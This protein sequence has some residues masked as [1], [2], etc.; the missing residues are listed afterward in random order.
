MCLSLLLAS[1]GSAQG[2]EDKLTGIVRFEAAVR[3]M[4]DLDRGFT[5]FYRTGRHA[6]RGYD[7]PVAIQ[8]G[9]YGLGS[10]I[11]SGS[12]ESRT[13]RL[14]EFA[15][16]ENLDVQKLREADPSPRISL[17]EAK[18]I[19][20]QL[21]HISDD[22]FP[23]KFT[24]IQEWAEGFELRAQ[25]DV[26]PR[27]LWQQGECIFEID[28]HR[29]VVVSAYMGYSPVL[30]YAD[31]PVVD[32]AVARA[33][34]IDAYLRYRPFAW[35]EVKGTGLGLAAPR[36]FKPREF[37]DELMELGLANI[38]IPIYITFFCEPSTYLPYYKAYGSS[39]FVYVDG[40]T[41]R[42]IAIRDNSG[43][44]LSLDVPADRPSPP[45]DQW[46][47]VSFLDS[48]G[49]TIAGNFTLIK[50]P[51]RYE[52]E[53]RAVWFRN[54]DEWVVGDYDGFQQVLKVGD[55]ATARWYKVSGPVT[56]ALRKAKAPSGSRFGANTLV[57]T[58]GN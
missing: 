41:G 18:R 35:T 15:C 12:L 48:K 28:R 29:G 57:E 20:T 27:M 3:L 22:R 14:L 10:G 52:F 34:A 38:A 42:A 19:C 46:F 36:F 1:L 44:I 23:L 21:Y 17:E 5:P 25:P 32:A 9:S 58:S 33:A 50:P 47:F 11:C 2:R 55:G 56:D 30:R 40:R 51:T 49:T 54:G 43:G 37:T 26:G 16:R 31:A 4:E 7:A 45:L 24:S 6:I 8:R 39:M 53:G 13:H